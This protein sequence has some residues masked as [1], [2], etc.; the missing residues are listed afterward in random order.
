MGND[1]KGSCNKMK[2][3]TKKQ[4]K[5]YIKNSNRKFHKTIFTCAYYCEIHSCWHLTSMPKQRS[6]DL[7]RK[8]NK[9]K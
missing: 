7:T 6:R 5:D 8:L 4:A 1:N 2:F 3:A 9:R